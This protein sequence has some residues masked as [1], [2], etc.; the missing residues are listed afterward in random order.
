MKSLDH[1]PMRRCLVGD[2]AIILPDLLKKKVAG[3]E[4]EMSNEEDH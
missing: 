3:F 2:F 4:Q 1:S